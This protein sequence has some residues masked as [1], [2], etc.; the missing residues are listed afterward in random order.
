[1]EHKDKAY[2]MEHKDKAYIKEHKDIAYSMENG[3]QNAALSQIMVTRDYEGQ[4]KLFFRYKLIKQICL[5]CTWMAMVST[6][7]Q[8]TLIAT[9][10]RADASRHRPGIEPASNVCRNVATITKFC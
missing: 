2:N 5:V 8:L 9:S 7:L 6:Q 1:M 3:E 10:F 4:E